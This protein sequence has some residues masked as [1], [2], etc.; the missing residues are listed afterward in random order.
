MEM[1]K[2]ISTMAG[3]QSINDLDL[4]FLGHWNSILIQ[5]ELPLEKVVIKI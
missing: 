1:K 3:N 5:G 4:L 2:R